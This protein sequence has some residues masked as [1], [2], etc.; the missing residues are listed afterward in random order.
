MKQLTEDK[1]VDLCLKCGIA[2]EAKFPYGWYTFSD[3][4]INT[5]VELGLKPQHKLLDIG[6]GPLR[7]GMQ[8]VPY[9][10]PNNYF[11]IDGF[12]PYLN[13]GQ[14][15]FKELEL[16]DNYS[17]LHNDSF[18]FGHFDDH[19]DFAIASAV[20][21]HLSKSQ[22]DKVFDEL[23]KVMNK[24]GVFLMTYLPAKTLSPR[25]FFFNG[26]YDSPMTS[27]PYCDWEYLNHLAEKFDITLLKSTNLTHPSQKV[28][29]FTF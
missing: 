5:L 26:Y 19:F 9:L 2:P 20:I 14:E 3:W 28:A 4:Q 1:L 27:S 23:K 6:C 16:S 17:V 15:I 22:V 8:A 24:D 21:T 12:K 25:G 11:A 18:E 10:E 13:L 7:L 29:V